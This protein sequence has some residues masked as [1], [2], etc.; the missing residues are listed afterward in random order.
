MD[1]I[2]LL[3]DSIRMFYAKYVEQEFAGR[4]KVVWPNENGRFSLYTLRC[5]FEW[6]KLAD[7]PQDVVAVHWNNG[8]WDVTRRT[9]D[10]EC[11]AS[12]E[13]YR[14]NLERIIFELRARFPRAKIVFATTTCVNPKLPQV[15]NE[16]VDAYNAVA[17][18]VMARH[19]VPIDDLHAVMAA[20]PEY[21]REDDLIHETDE[22]ARVLA[23]CV[24]ESIERALD[25]RSE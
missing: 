22:G 10:G 8:L 14:R 1:T 12:P 2:L 9:M 4:M 16:D 6:E 19:G 13:E 7:S 3:G 17:L 21:I 25:E 23:R 5:L 18:E 11:L 15:K 20:H 24:R